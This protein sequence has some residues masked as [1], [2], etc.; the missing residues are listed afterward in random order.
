MKKIHWFIILLVVFSC[1]RH[2]RFEINGYLESDDK[3]VIY[4]DE[5]DVTTI[6]PLDSVKVRRHGK[7]K[8]KGKIT[9][10]KFYNLHTGDK[11]IITLLISPGEKVK[12][13]CQK[14]NFTT[15]YKIEGSEDSEHIR[16]INL[17][18]WSTKR[19]IDS[20]QTLIKN[21]PGTN[22]AYTSELI[23][24]YEEITYEQRRYSISFILN[25]LTSMASIY[26][27]YQRLDPETFVL[28]DNYDVQLLKITGAALDT[29]Y[30][31]SKHVKALVSDAANLEWQ[32]KNQG[33]RQ[34]IEISESS[35][36]EVALPN[37]DGDTIRLSSLKGKIILLSFWASWEPVSV[38]H[39]VQ[40][41]EMYNKY[42]SKGFEIY[43]VSLDNNKDA[44]L[45][46][47]QYDELPWINVSDLSFPESQIA[48]IYNV[49]SLPTTFLINQQGEIIARDLS[50]FDLDKKLKN[51]VD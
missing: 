25:H 29:I 39:N 9:V 20:I 43:Q 6:I 5:Q 44:W 41:L 2:E 17:K 37:P 27:L 14:K 45:K 4:L 26:A 18:L 15:S 7:F 8:F 50:K 1:D 38:S 47:I 51:L 40:L 48:M 31:G 21:D 19:K 24:K 33:F 32:I 42:H 28:N 35:F 16:Q 30:P 34:L 23:K 49:Q 22:A 3:S 13:R 46:A 12:I 11:N 10:P 36:P